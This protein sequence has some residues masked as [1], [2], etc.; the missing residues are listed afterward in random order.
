[1]LLSVVDYWTI[2]CA[3]VEFCSES[4]VRWEMALRPSED[5]AE[6]RGNQFLAMV[7]MREWAVLWML[8]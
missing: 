6:L 2:A 7:L 4:P 8:R 1:M 5:L 3:M